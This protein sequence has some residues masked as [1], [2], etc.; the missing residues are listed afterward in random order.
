M[1]EAGATYLH[2]R[3]RHPRNRP[4]IP[5]RGAEGSKQRAAYP[6]KLISIINARFSLM[7]PWSSVELSP[8]DQE[9]CLFAPAP[10]S[11]S[12]FWPTFW[13]VFMRILILSLNIMGPASRIVL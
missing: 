8:L 7:D 9:S 13:S 10:W 2:Q 12:R 5:S 6:N 4:E 3:P 1:D 11:R